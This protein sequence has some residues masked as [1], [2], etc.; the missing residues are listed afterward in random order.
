MLIYCWC[1][2][3]TRKQTLRETGL[4]K[5]T[6]TDFYNMFREICYLEYRQTGQ[7]GGPGVIVQI[8]ETHICTRKYNVGR[9]LVS[10]QF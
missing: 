8:D 4:S 5:Q 7:I 10:E 2:E 9:L 3:F 6:I 1:Y